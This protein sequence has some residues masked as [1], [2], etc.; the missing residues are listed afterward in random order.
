MDV[1]TLAILAPRDSQH[2]E[3]Q[4]E[5]IRL[6]ISHPK[7]LSLKVSISQPQLSLTSQLSQN[8]LSLTTREIRVS[9]RPFESNRRI[10]AKKEEN[11]AKAPPIWNE[12]YAIIFEEV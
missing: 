7:L 11:P 1:D 5:H 10:S 6:L 3:Q 4:M 8:Q 12:E 2:I 9:N